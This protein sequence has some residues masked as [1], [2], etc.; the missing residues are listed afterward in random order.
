MSGW[1]SPR[2]RRRR[3]RVSSAR[4]RACSCSPELRTGRPRAVGSCERVGVVSPAV[5]RRVCRSCSSSWRAR[6]FSLRVGSPR[7][8]GSPGRSRRSDIRTAR[9]SSGS[10]CAVGA[11]GDEDVRGQLLPPRPRF[12]V[13]QHIVRE[14]AAQKS[15]HRGRPVRSGRSV[16]GGACPQQ[17]GG[18]PVQQQL[19][20]ARRDQAAAREQAA[21]AAQPQ[22]IRR[23]RASV[24]GRASALSVIRVSGTGSGASHASSVSNS[25]A[26]GD[27]VCELVESDGPRRRQRRRVGAPRVVV[28]RVGGP[29]GEQLQVG[30]HVDRRR[31][32]QRPGLVEGQRQVPDGVGDSVG[33]IGAQARGQGAQQGDGL[34]AG[35]LSRARPGWRCRASAGCGR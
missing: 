10:G 3:V 31:G 5:R 23:A 6:S 13:V 14:R 28:E 12:R 11:G 33:V 32:Q 25:S 15:D 30:G 1:S 8:T 34:V 18:H 24:V 19:G 17:G 22:R 9:A 29:L 2:M 20:G 16:I 21:A 4:A 26:S 27:A 35:E 7:S